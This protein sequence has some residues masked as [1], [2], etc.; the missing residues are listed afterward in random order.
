MWYF[1]KCNHTLDHITNDDGDY[2]LAN[3]DQPK[4]KFSN[5][6]KLSASNIT[7]YI[8]PVTSKL[9]PLFPSNYSAP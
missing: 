3:D 4:E 7:M 8:E 2:Y 6:L 1:Q 5:N 9:T